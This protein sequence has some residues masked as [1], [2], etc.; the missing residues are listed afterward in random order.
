MGG[1]TYGGIL[2]T[3]LSKLGKAVEDWK[4][5]V[6]QLDKLA[7]DAADGLVKYADG[8]QWAGQNA[9]VTKDFVH[10]TA[11]EFRDAHTEAT[12]I[13][14]VLDEAHTDLTWA[15]QSI[16][17]ATEYARKAGITVVDN[18]DGTVSCIFSVCAAGDAQPTDKDRADKQERED[19]I[20]TL[21]AR[22]QETDAAAGRALKKSHGGDE[23]NFGHAKY[24]SVDEVRREQHLP[25]DEPV[26][27]KTDKWGS[28]TVKPVAEFFSYRSWMNGADAGLHGEWGKAWDG[29]MGGAPS[30]SGGLVSKG[31]EKNIGGGGLHRKPSAV[32]IL[33]KFGGKVFGA[34]VAVVATGIDFYYTPPGGN[35]E[36]GDTK[37]IAPG[38]PGPVRYK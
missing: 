31:L 9:D 3:D 32:N 13:W 30:W 33:G 14:T 10:K 12:S 28:G 25:S 23:H 15:R 35:K 11:R 7:K 29:F 17:E 37:V 8:A 5:M 26:E 19:Y 1:I 21:I 4:D 36:P 2:R 22:A 18:S 38:A 16:E 24:T 6:S 27:T 34:P 20:N